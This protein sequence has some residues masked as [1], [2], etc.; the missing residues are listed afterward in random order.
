MLAITREIALCMNELWSI[1]NAGPSF[2]LN[3][4]IVIVKSVC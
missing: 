3:Y 1:K 2:I 4:F